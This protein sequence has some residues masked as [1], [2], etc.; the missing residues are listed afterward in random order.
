MLWHCVPDSIC[1]SR[2]MTFMYR[3]C[4]WIQPVWGQG[5]CNQAVDTGQ[6]LRIDRQK[7]FSL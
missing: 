1:V 7:M 3:I 6:Q 2:D 4:Q 5:T